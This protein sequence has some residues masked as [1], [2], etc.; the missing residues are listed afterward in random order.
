MS[1]FHL[2]TPTWWT[3]IFPFLFLKDL[4][5]LVSI[6]N[7]FL[8]YLGGLHASGTVCNIFD[9]HLYLTLRSKCRLQISY[10]RL[11]QQ[12][13]PRQGLAVWLVSPSTQKAPLLCPAMALR[14]LLHP[15]A[16]P[17]AD[18]PAFQLQSRRKE[19]IPNIK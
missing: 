13:S 4:W 6:C 19:T 11:L 14:A 1:M 16:H 12:A 5:A 17:F 2:V 8:S 9:W 3:M 10:C 15:R 7:S 18:C